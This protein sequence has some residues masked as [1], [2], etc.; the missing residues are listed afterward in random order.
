M[1]TC[2]ISNTIYSIT[3]NNCPK[4][5]EGTH[6]QYI[7]ETGCSL[8]ERFREHFKYARNPCCE[9]YEN[10][11]MAKYFRNNHLGETPNL[12]LDI[13]CKNNK[14][15][16]RKINEALLQLQLKPVLNGKEELLHSKQFLI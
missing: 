7:G 4:N 15:L 13:L 11:S 5:S 12:H 14:T 10:K 1:G 2:M 9:S 8:H 3:C 16:S 6:P